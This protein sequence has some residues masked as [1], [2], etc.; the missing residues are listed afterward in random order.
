MIVKFRK[1]VRG[2]LLTIILRIHQTS[3]IQEPKGFSTLLLFTLGNWPHLNIIGG[4]DPTSAVKFAIDP[5]FVD[6]SPNV[7]DIAFPEG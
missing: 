6:L 3:H 1:S 5:V 2:H 4:K 7:D